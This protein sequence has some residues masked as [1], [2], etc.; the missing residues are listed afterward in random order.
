MDRLQSRE[1][2]L[3]N[4]R[5]NNKKSKNP[6]TDEQLQ[7]MA[8]DMTPKLIFNMKNRRRLWA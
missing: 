5:D 1:E 6:C 3:K 8:I 7:L 4:L 2:R